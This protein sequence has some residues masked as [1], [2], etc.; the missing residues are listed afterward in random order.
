MFHTKDLYSAVGCQL[1]LTV[2][3]QY[4][5]PIN[6]FK[7]SHIFEAIELN[8]AKLHIEDYSVSQTTLDEVIYQYFVFF[9]TDLHACFHLLWSTI[10]VPNL[11]QE[12]RISKSV[13]MNLQ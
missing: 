5:I 11:L 1:K 9:Q 7:L 12:T 10:L 4:Q 3:L 2:F 8:K 6:E 13:A